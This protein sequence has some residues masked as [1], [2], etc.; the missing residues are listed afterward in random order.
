MVLLSNIINFSNTTEGELQSL[1]AGKVTM[2]FK[3]QD[4]IDDYG[5]V[6]KILESYKKY[7]YDA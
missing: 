6:E 4:K 7:D 1:T 5:K 3:Q 2:S